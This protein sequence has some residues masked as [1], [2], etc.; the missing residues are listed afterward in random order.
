[1]HRIKLTIEYDGTEYNGW[2]FQ[3]NQVTI[4]EEI[5][6]A[7]SI[8]FN[9]D[10]RIV[11]AGRTDTGV[12]ARNQTA[13]LEIPEF[14][15]D[16]LKHSLN[17]ILKKD[18]RIK[19]IQNCV[20]DFHARFDAITRHYCYQISLHPTATD[21][22]FAWQIFFPI[23]L[24]LMQDGADLIAG[25]KNFK[26]FCKTKSEVKH[27]LCDIS[28]SHW[29]FKGN[30]LIYEIAANRFLH[31]MV[32]AI[33]GTLVDLGRGHI[34]L[35]YLKKIIKKKDR[36]LILNTAPAHGLFLENVIY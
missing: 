8:I 1:M 21:R 35:G 24:A 20:Y 25:T 26:A 16:K 3:K 19:N 7:L 22:A 4:Q 18:I 6:R 29:S 30:L 15:L 5:E 27:H 9:K 13:H 17:G 28:K 31:G 34:D 23:N 32:R 10:I 2:Q 36:I 33:V 12:H 11:G 14:D